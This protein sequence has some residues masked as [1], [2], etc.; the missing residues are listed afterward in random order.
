M[1]MPDRGRPSPAAAALI[2]GALAHLQAGRLA[3]AETALRQVLAVTPDDPDAVHLLGVAALQQGK[4]AEAE[5]LLT[6]AT[7]L[8]R[9]Q[10]AA[11]NNLGVAL[12]EQGKLSEAVAAYRKALAVAPDFTDGKSVV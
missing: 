8:D 1:K 3:E 11:W 6:R 4:P 10:P 5:R 2:N 9:R 12:R 7:Q